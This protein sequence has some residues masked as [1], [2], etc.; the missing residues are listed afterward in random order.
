MHSLICLHRLSLSS[1]TYKFFFSINFHILL[2]R[3]FT[4][5]SMYTVIP[6]SA[7]MRNMFITYY[8]LQICYYICPTNARIGNV[9]IPYYSLPTRG[10]DGSVGIATRYGLNG[11][12]IESRW[13]AIFTASFHTDPGAH[14]A[15]HTMSTGSFTVVKRPERD[16]DHPLP[17]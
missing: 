6:T 12:G 17:I 8:S 2:I 16:A 15:S 11:P 10:R 9:F 1:K 14:P 5:N 7:P 3:A 4:D 13:G